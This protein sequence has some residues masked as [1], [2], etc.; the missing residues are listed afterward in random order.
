MIP[1]TVV[2]VCPHCGGEHLQKNGHTP[3]GARRALCVERRRTFTLSPKGPQHSEKFKDQVLAAYQDRMSLRGIHRTF[4]V[5]YASVMRWP[6]EKASVL[7][8]SWTRSCPARMGTCLNSMSFGVSCKAKRRRS[9]SGWRSAEE[10]ARSWPGRWETGAN[11]A[12]PTC[13]PQLAQELPGT[14]HPQRPLG[15]LRRCLSG[16]DASRLRQGGRR[17]LPRRTL[18]WHPARSRWPPRPQSL[19]LFQAPGEPSGRHPLL[20]RY[21][22]PANQAINIG[23]NTTRLCMECRCFAETLPL[24][25]RC[26]PCVIAPPPIGGGGEAILSAKPR[27]ASFH[28]PRPQHETSGPTS[29]IPCLLPLSN[30]PPVVLT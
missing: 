2:H 14:R 24:R 1:T 26:A 30:Q 10:R 29:S 9:G 5:C 6:G 20:H 25:L 11:K 12:P 7:R 13:A 19:F 18:V 21:L 22:Q 28:R 17:N 15:S 16:Q 4:G 23:V 27:C 3:R 8:R